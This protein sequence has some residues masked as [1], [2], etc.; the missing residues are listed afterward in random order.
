MSGYTS[1]Q[2]QNVNADPVEQDESDELPISHQ[3]T[4]CGIGDA[5]V[6]HFTSAEFF[7]VE[8][9]GVATVDVIRIGRLNFTSTVHWRTEDRSAIAGE[10]Y[11]AST[12]QIVFE[13]GESFKT[14][15]VPLVQSPSFDTALEFA[16]KLDSPVNCELGMRLSVCRVMVIDDDRFPTDALADR[17]LDE[18]GEVHAEGLGVH[19]LVAWMSFAFTH[20]PSIWWKSIVTFVLDLFHNGYYLMNIYVRVYLVD[21]VLNMH[22]DVDALIIPGDR[23][24]SALVLAFIWTC[25]NL[26]L[27]IIDYAQVG[28]LD[29]GFTLRKYLRVNFFR[30]YLNY[31]EH[32]LRLC[33]VHDLTTCSASLIP[34][35]VENGYLFFFDML[36]SLGKIGCVGF[37]MLCKD[38]SSALPLLLFPV[39]MLSFACCTQDRLLELAQISS[40]EQEVTQ[41][42]LV[43]ASHSIKLIRAYMQ[44]ADVVDSFEERLGQQ[45]AVTITMKKFSFWSDQVVPWVTLLTI[46]IYMGYGSHQVLKGEITVGVF[47]ATIAVY[48]DLGDRFQGVNS[49][50]Q[51][52]LGAVE[53]LMQLT[54]F[55]NFTTDLPTRMMINRERSN[56]VKDRLADCVKSDAIPDKAFWDGIRIHFNNVSIEHIAS[57]QHV[58]IKVNQDTI[59]LVSGPHG[60]GKATL[61]NFF[62]QKVKIGH[63][64]FMPFLLS[65][66]ISR[67]P[68]VIS[69]LS[70]LENLCY[71]R[72]VTESDIARARS[73]FLRT[74]EG[75]AIGNES[76]WLIEQFDKDVS[77]YKSGYISERDKQELLNID[78]ATSPAWHKKLSYNE[79]SR[80]HL[81]RALIYSPN[82]MVLHKPCDDVDTDLVTST[83]SLLRQ[84]V[85]DRG[86]QT[87]EDGK[88]DSGKHPWHMRHP[89]TVFLT[90]GKHIH[91]KD[92]EAWVDHHWCLDSGTLKFQNGGYHGRKEARERIYL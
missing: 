76:H 34:T 58:E 86:L 8:N 91:R 43:R 62:S 5:D 80:I 25:P 4:L 19:L 18:R 40:E 38:P 21:H 24:T 55:M 67:V 89:R 16:L 45:R 65:L 17:I 78:D 36:R 53:P 71:G 26:L 42:L 77:E 20:V 7:A 44:R 30:T 92:I 75:I 83:M 90:C 32:S 27:L 14:C 29:M 31:T 82:I 46:G 54:R 85:E 35:I 47:L 41:S 11:E 10:R 52:A 73:I 57:L 48:K 23:S 60:C 61:L 9:E 84:F 69:Y 68:D 6:V 79:M 3:H 87:V 59:T 37:F 22:S 51:D 81:A 64:H 2:E 74:L 63:I 50:I 12:G 49:K 39:M 70:L 88:V 13:P 56:F 15:E 1:L 66:Q 28:P 72:S 33:P